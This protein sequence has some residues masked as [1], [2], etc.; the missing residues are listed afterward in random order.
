MV[1]HHPATGPQQRAGDQREGVLSTVGDQDLIWGRRE[2]SVGVSPG[3]GRAQLGQP[4]RAVAVARQVAGKLVQRPAVRPVQS[5]AGGGRGCV[6]EVDQVVADG[7]RRRLA[8]PAARGHPGPTARPG[9]S[10]EITLLTEGGVRR[11]HRRAAD[12]EDRGEVPLARHGGGQRQ[13]SVE[14]QQAGQIGEPAMRGPRAGRPVA[15]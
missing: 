11:R 6:G 4:D 10:A 14:D 1:D 9:A 7:S 2:P 3:D 12:P 15:Q 8:G 5:L 13:P